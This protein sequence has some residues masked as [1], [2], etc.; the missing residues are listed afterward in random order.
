MVAISFADFGAFRPAEFPKSVTACTALMSLLYGAVGVVGY[1]S[2]GEAITGIV[3]FS[4]GDSPRVRI[5]A[6]LILVQATSQ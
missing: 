3:I 5:A 1:W 2:R 6:A 4:L